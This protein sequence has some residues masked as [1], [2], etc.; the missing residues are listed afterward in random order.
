MTTNPLILIVS[1]DARL[2]PEIQAGCGGLSSCS[3]VLRTVPDFPLAV[4]AT[5]N[6]RPQIAIIEFVGDMLTLRTIAEEL[7]AASPETMLVCAF[8][9][10]VFPPDVAESAVLIEALRC[11]IADFIRRPVSSA[12]LAQLF[13]RLATSGEVRSRTVGKLISFISNKGGVGKSTLSVNTAVAL[14]KQY[15]DRVLLVDASLQMGLCAP[16]LDIRPQHSLLDAARQRSRLDETLLR[17]LTTAHPS[18]LDVLAAPPSAL[19]AGELDDEV[20]SRV[21]TIARRTYDCVIVDT[22][23]L[24]DRVVMAILDLSDRSYIV[25][26]NSVP[27]VLSGV[28]FLELLRGMDYPPARQEI[29]LNRFMRG[30][31]NPSARDVAERLQRNVNH[32]IPFDRKVQTAANLGEPFVTRAGYWS[33]SGGAMRRLAEEIDSSMRASAMAGNG[34]TAAAAAS[35][36]V[37]GA[38]PGDVE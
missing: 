11:G 3:P 5:R 24:L 25:L 4:E 17:Q 13:D 36:T 2:A 15:R 10:D 35:A 38:G 7:R 16:M 9:P 26:D 8:R 1:P 32:V 22:F 21:L 30:W 12:D 20:M 6:W 14:A 18:G 37:N 29:V 34:N 33:S 19:E 31:G 28:K 23:P 27:T